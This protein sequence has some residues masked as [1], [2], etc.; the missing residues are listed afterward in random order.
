MFYYDD[1]NQILSFP[2]S[3][4]DAIAPDPFVDA[5]QGKAYLRLVD[6]INLVERITTIKQM[7]L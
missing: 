7:C 6:L 3:W 1:N 5:A 2:A 4:T